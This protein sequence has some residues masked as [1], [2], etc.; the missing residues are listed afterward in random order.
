MKRGLNSILFYLEIAWAR[1]SIF[2]VQDFKTIEEDNLS[3]LNIDRFDGTSD[4]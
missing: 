4:F 1:F 3:H 2:I